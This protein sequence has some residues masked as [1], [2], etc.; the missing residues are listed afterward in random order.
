MSLGL[1]LL[2]LQRFLVWALGA[3]GR[4]RVAIDRMPANFLR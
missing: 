1:T 4:Q 3:D 2:S